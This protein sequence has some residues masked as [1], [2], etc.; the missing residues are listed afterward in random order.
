MDPEE[1]KLK[2]VVS[3]VGLKRDETHF[4][5]FNL[6]IGVVMNTKKNL[7]YREGEQLM[8]QLRK[9]LL[10]KEVEITSNIF[11][12]PVCGRGFNT[13]Q[14]MKQHMRMTH[15]KKKKTKKRSKKTTSTNKPKKASKKKKS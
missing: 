2:G 10:G 1:P 3:E 8:M 6:K 7:S 11:R 4:T 14:G 13:E 12:C 5:S 15:E 9:E